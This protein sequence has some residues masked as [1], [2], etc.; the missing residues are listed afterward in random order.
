VRK[1]C[2]EAQDTRSGGLFPLVDARLRLLTRLVI[3]QQGGLCLDDVIAL[4]SKCRPTASSS[5]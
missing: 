2:K 1:M 4:I 5:R 3:L